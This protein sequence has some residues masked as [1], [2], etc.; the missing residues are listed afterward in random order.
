MI[1]LG[2]QRKRAQFNKCALA[3]QSIEAIDRVNS[4]RNETLNRE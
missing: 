2:D 1:L 4:S 3:I